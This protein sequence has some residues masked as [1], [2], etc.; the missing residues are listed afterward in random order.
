MKQVE[1][2]TE[3][4]FSEARLGDCRKPSRRIDRDRD[5]SRTQLWRSTGCPTER[6]TSC[7]LGGMARRETGSDNLIPHPVPAGRETVHTV[8]THITKLVSLHV[9]KPRVV[10]PPDEDVLAMRADSCGVPNAEAA[11]AHGG[12]FGSRREHQPPLDALSGRNEHKA[13]LCPTH[14]NAAA[15][16]CRNAS[17]DRGDGDTVSR[18]LDAH[19]PSAHQRIPLGHSRGV[20][21]ADEDSIQGHGSVRNRSKARLQKEGKAGLQASQTANPAEFDGVFILP[22]LASLVCVMVLG[23]LLLPSM[24]QLLPIALLPVLAMF[25]A[26]TFYIVSKWRRHNDANRLREDNDSLLQLLRELVKENEKL[27]SSSNPRAVDKKIQKRTQ[28]VKSS[29]L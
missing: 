9:G 12:R 6:G 5:A 11:R 16:S 3:Q 21:F 18:R 15:Q 28:I 29:V 14:E 17:R 10:P 1:V 27:A 2:S 19:P 26:A 7:V 25:G 23:I 24:Q 13:R 8:Q 22:V 4:T 20:A